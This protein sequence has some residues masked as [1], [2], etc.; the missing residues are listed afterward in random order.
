MFR[1]IDRFFSS[2]NA[3]H[4]I[5]TVLWIILAVRAFMYHQWFWFT[6]YVLFIVATNYQTIRR[7]FFKVTKPKKKVGSGFGNN[8]SLWK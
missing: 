1:R 4:K 2:G 6:F 8:S 7:T 3:L 5:F